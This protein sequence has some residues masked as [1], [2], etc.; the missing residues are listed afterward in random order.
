MN[1]TC[2]KNEFKGQTL[3]CYKLK[4]LSRIWKGRTANASMIF[5]LKNFLQ[6]NIKITPKT[7]RKEGIY[8]QGCVSIIFEVLT[9]H[10]QV[11]LSR[12][13]TRSPT[14]FQGIFFTREDIQRSVSVFGMSPKIFRMKYRVSLCQNTSEYHACT[15]HVYK[16]TPPKFQI[17]QCHQNC[18]HLKMFNFAPLR[19]GVQM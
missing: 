7:F 15:A 8:H 16:R 18:G 19:L 3:K 11:K 14:T 1:G 17:A 5:F 2:E 13:K 4:I 9:C 10:M 12:S 6:K